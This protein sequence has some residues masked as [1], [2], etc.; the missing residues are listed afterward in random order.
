VDRSKSGTKRSLLVEAGGVPI[1]LSVAGA[2]RNDFKLLEA[3]LQSL[4]IVKPA[5]TKARPQHVC[6]DKGY[7]F[8]EVRAI[9]QAYG[10]VAHIRSRGEEA[11]AKK[12]KPGQK[13]RCRVVERTHSWFNRFGSILTRWSKKAENYLGMLCFVCGLTAYRAASFFG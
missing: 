8:E 7:D 10:F 1:G 3:T 2:N 9:L 5:P 13:A 4:P 6:L 12:R 11:A